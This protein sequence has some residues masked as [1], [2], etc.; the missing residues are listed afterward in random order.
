MKNFDI[1][2]QA[3]VEDHDEDI[4]QNVP[5]VINQRFAGTAVRIK[6]VTIIREGE[7]T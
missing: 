1:L 4:I 6:S 2:I 5:S 3:A 7:S